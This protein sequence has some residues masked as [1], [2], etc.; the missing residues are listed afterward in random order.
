MLLCFIS[1]IPLAESGSYTHQDDRAFS[2]IKPQ[3]I[4]NLL[5]ESRKKYKRTSEK[6]DKVFTTQ[7]IIQKIFNVSKSHPKPLPK[8]MTLSNQSLPLVRMHCIIPCS[9]PL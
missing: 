2:K 1:K 7:S 9:S 4:L 3:S 6:C 8:M 5:A